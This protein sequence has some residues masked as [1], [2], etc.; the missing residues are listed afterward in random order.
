[1]YDVVAAIAEVEIVGSIANGVDVTVVVVL[2]VGT[3]VG[4]DTADGVTE[5]RDINC[6]YMYGHNSLYLVLQH[7]QAL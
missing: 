7:C 4:G 3:V 6:T 5:N 2:I 1:M